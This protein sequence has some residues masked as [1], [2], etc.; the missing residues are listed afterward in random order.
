MEGSR[1]T[2]GT[3]VGES[4]RLGWEPGRNPLVLKS[5]FFLHHTALSLE[6]LTREQRRQD[7]QRSIRSPG[8][9]I[10]IS[11]AKLENRTCSWHL[12]GGVCDFLG[13]CNMLCFLI[14]S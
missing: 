13:I 2:E 1:L 4:K 12:L 6:S 3:G 14:H 8:A 11:A 7:P 5:G 9:E 10:P